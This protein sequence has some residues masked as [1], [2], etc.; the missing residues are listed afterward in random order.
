MFSSSPHHNSI[1][2]PTDQGGWISRSDTLEFVRCSKRGTDDI[3]SLHNVNFGCIEKKVK[4]KAPQKTQRSAGEPTLVKL[5]MK[6]WALLLRQEFILTLCRHSL[7]KKA[8]YDKTWMGIA[9]SKGFTLHSILLIWLNWKE[10][11]S[12]MWFHSSPPSKKLLHLH[13]KTPFVLP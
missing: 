12:K 2:K 1:L 8:F 9:F 7:D 6:E 3:R 10:L 13:F 5:S 11:Y 4:N